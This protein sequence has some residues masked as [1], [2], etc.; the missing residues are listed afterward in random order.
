MTQELTN[1]T[2]TKAFADFLGGKGDTLTRRAQRNYTEVLDLL[3]EFLEEHGITEMGA[4]PRR[5]AGTIDQVLALIDEF[6]DDYL[7]STIKAEREFLRQAGVVSR[8]LCRWLK[9][10]GAKQK[11]GSEASTASAHA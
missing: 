6:D 10:L 1:I 11:K 9:N 4:T 7:V 2:I 3:G 5:G 8:D